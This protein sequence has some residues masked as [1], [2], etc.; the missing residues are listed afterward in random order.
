MTKTHV[1][2]GCHNCAEAICD[3][4]DSDNPLKVSPTGRLVEGPSYLRNIMEMAAFDIYPPDNYEGFKN[5][6]VKG[7]D[8][9]RYGGKMSDMLKQSI[10]D[11]YRAGQRYIFHRGRVVHENR[12]DDIYGRAARRFNQ[13]VREYCRADVLI[14]GDYAYIERMILLRMLLGYTPHAHLLKAPY[15]HPRGTGIS[16]IRNEPAD[17]ETADMIGGL[18]V[19]WGCP[20][21]I[22]RRVA[23]CM[24]ASGRY[25]CR[26]TLSRAALRNLLNA[27][28]A[29]QVV[30]M[31]TDK[32]PSFEKSDSDRDIR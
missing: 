10:G 4:C 25:D 30:V 9:G 24:Y 6:Y 29:L 7:T 28:M 13:K 17:R 26:V 16:L 5:R 22:A 23:D 15:G 8:T 19:G 2:P 12:I 27:A 3:E 21:F 11:M 31:L 20:S 14:F 18:M 32:S 1:K